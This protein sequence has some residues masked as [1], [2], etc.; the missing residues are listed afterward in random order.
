MARQPIPLRFTAVA[1]TQA[2]R[3]SAKDSA[4]V[5]L[6]QHAQERMEERGIS[7]LEVFRILREG[8][9][10]VAPTREPNG[11]WKAEIEKRLPG[12]RDAAVVTV[13]RVGGL[14]V[15]VTVMWRDVR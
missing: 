2:I 10:F 3:Q 14:L 6:T 12:G 13:I 9:V 11:D 15:V 7:D 8:E 4:Q 1:A 5:I